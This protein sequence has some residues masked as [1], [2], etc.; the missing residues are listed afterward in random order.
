[1]IKDITND[2]K[3]FL[4][5]KFRS[6]PD[7]DNLCRELGIKNVYTDNY[8]EQITDIV[9][10][11]ETNYP[12]PVEKVYHAIKKLR[13]KFYE[14]IDV[15]FEIESE[16]V[17]IPE[18][19]KPEP[20]VKQV[21]ILSITASPDSSIMY[22]REQTV[23]LDSF[24]PYTGEGVAVDMPDPVSSTLTELDKFLGK[25]P[26]DI[27]IISAHGTKEGKLMFEDEE[28]NE[29]AVAGSQIAEKLQKFPKRPS[30]VIFSA[31]H[32]AR[33]DDDAGLL[34]PARE[35]YDTGAIGCVIGMRKEI[36]QL[37]SIDF[38]KGFI[39]P[40]LEGSTVVDAFVNGKQAIREGEGRRLQDMGNKWKFINEDAIPQL[41]IRPESETLARTDFHD[42]TIGKEK[43]DIGGF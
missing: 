9:K 18:D 17:S 41:F 36:S 10:C 19:T 1:M 39:G 42:E 16:K 21:K 12:K 43:T 14:E 23:L 37:A 32:S 34:T 22:E 38:N 2:I 11:I 20:L 13:P 35:L 28:G 7:I 5:D 15:L 6:S 26:Y 8:T 4:T 30:V 3:S 27:L 40:L 25:Y 31:C 29:V 24:A 33:R